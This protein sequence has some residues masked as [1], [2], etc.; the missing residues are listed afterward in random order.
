MKAI[1]DGR[2]HLHVDDYHALRT[3]LAFEASLDRT[4]G[5]QK[6]SRVLRDAF[7]VTVISACSV[8]S[9]SCRDGF[10]MFYVF[11][12]GD[13]SRRELKPRQ[14]D[15]FGQDAAKVNHEARSVIARRMREA[16]TAVLRDI[17]GV[18]DGERAP[19]RVLMLP[20]ELAEDEESVYRLSGIDALLDYL[21]R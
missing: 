4:E 15:Y 13:I 11:E 8:K 14:I 2:T 12:L 18:P 5:M 6:V 7:G 20:H 1:H 16:V 17:I 19:F 21:G 9:L 10:D 3:A